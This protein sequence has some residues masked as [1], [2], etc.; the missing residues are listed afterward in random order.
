M[1]L[2]SISSPGEW[3]GSLFGDR[4]AGAICDAPPLKTGEELLLETG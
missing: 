2:I 4:S 3:T 1:P